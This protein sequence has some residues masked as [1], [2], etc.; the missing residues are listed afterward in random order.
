M[1]PTDAPPG[2]RDAVGG[3]RALLT[4]LAYS[5]IFTLLATWTTRHRDVT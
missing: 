5:L 2:V 4:L 3:D 1:G